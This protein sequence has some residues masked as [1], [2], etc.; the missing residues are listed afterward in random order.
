[1]LILPIRDDSVLRRPPAVT[2][3]VICVCSAVFLWQLGLGPRAFTSFI[4]SFGMI[5]AVLFGY[6]ELPSRLAAVPAWATVFTSMFIHGG[7]LHLLGNMLYLWLF[8]RGVE[9]ALGPS[10]FGILYLASGVA[11]AMTQALTSPAAEVPMIGASGAIAGA[12][13]A[14]LIL[15]PRANVI[16]FVWIFIFVRFISV[17]AVILLAL[18]FA[19]QLLGALA[20]PPNEPGVAFWAHVGG[21]VAGVILV[22]I[23]RGRDAAL[24]RPARSSPFGVTRPRATKWRTWSGSVP[25]AGDRAKK[26][27]GPWG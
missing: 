10:R 21:F 18:W 13:G 19:T 12:L 1:M 24:L 3:G 16:L 7:W 11:A 27:R 8:G 2:Y 23:L 20:A 4:F 22:L 15:H 17:P 14:Y 5:P 26:R 6:A 25:P 9:S